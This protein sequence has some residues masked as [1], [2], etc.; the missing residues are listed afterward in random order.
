MYK[1]LIPAFILSL[2]ANIVLSYNLH[3]SNMD[4]KYA[5]NTSRHYYNELVKTKRQLESIIIPKGFE[6]EH[7]PQKKTNK[8]FAKKRN[9][10]TVAPL[11]TKTSEAYIPIQGNW[12]SERTLYSTEEKES[13]LPTY[14]YSKEQ[15]ERDL[16]K[17]Q[18]TVNDMK[19][20]RTLNNIFRHS[21]PSIT[22]W[23]Y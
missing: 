21:K 22:G 17:F 1:I 14:D 13:T 12:T 23:E 20:D 4:L 16:Y 8:T 6:I 5:E 15:N 7:T 18:K 3:L 11:Q 19:L 2:I 9:D 10:F